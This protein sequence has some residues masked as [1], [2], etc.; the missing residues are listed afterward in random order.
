M[1]ESSVAESMPPYSK[2][3]V[4]RLGERLRSDAVSDDDLL[5]LDTHRRSFQTSYELVITTVRHQ[6]GLQP[7]GRPAKSTSA[8][9][10]KLRRESIRLSQMQDIAGCRVVVADTFEQADVVEKLQ[11]IFPECSVVDR[12]KK[13]SHGYRAVHVIVKHAEQSIEIQVR[14]KLQHTW[15]ELSEKA[16][17]V[18]DA[19]IKYGGGSERDRKLLQATSDAIAAHEEA[20]AL[21]AEFEGQVSQILDDPEFENGAAAK[22][23]TVE[24]LRQSVANLR[25]A[26]IATQ[27]TIE[28]VLADATRKFSQ[29]EREER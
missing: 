4:D 23:V 9:R 24:Q 6:L 27:T 22:G 20:V 5:L 21:L 25:A 11:V 29:A 16:A 8:I 12:R 28:N 3:N 14:T 13:A 17:D 7:T 19:A 1:R 10:E 15:A 2:S 18:I 26:T